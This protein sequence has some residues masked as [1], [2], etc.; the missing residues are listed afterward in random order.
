MGSIRITRRVSIDASRI[1]TRA[2]RW[3]S[4]IAELT[5]NRTPADTSHPASRRIAR[6]RAYVLDAKNICACALSAG[7]RSHHD[8]ARPRLPVLTGLTRVVDH[9]GSAAFPMLRS[10][11]RS[12]MMPFLMSLRPV[13]WLALRA[14]LQENCCHK[15]ATVG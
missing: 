2:S 15:A 5:P 11:S 13:S 9:C 10:P 6:Q 14:A 1:A 8:D 12:P 3:R 4:T 7:Q